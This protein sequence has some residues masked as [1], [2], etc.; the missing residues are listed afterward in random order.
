MHIPLNNIEISGLTM[1]G[2]E[3]HDYDFGGRM[4]MHHTMRGLYRNTA[5]I[6][7]VVDS[8]DSHSLYFVE[9]ELRRTLAEEA[10]VGVPLLLLANKN[11]LPGAM[12]ADD[13]EKRMNLSALIGSTRSYR[14][15]SVSALG[16]R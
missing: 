6:V 9:D 15:L 12:T 7:F 13:I 11:D 5:G 14:V 4:P 3:A 2:L 16:D 1:M 10:L 8:S